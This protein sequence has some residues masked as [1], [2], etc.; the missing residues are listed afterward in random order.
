MKFKF[1]SNVKRTSFEESR[2]DITKDQESL[3]KHILDLYSKHGFP[4][5][6]T[7][8][9][10]VFNNNQEIPFEFAVEPNFDGEIVY[11]D[12]IAIENAGHI[13]SEDG[14][15]IDLFTKEQC[16]LNSPH[17][18]VSYNNEEMVIDLD[19]SIRNGNITNR[20]KKQQ[21]KEYVL[22]HKTEIKRA[23]EEFRKGNNPIK[24]QRIV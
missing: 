7:Q 5:T 10:H 23:W 8:K 2:I 1:I 6:D 22:K 21:A 18:H 11:L 3:K 24:N 16:H 12:I 20:K 14:L 9:L 13:Y 17:V 4:A 19:G 15:V